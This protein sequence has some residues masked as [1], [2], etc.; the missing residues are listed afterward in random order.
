MIKQIVIVNANVRSPIRLVWL[1]LFLL[2]AT[3]DSELDS[4]ECPCI[5]TG[6]YR[7]LVDVVLVVILVYTRIK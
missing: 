3:D 2:D 1:Q 6:S 5:A 4:H 7:T